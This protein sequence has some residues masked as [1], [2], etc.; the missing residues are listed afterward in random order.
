MMPSGAVETTAQRGD[1]FG[2]AGP[3]WSVHAGGVQGGGG[4]RGQDFGCGA[5]FALP[6][7]SATTS[8]T[9]PS[10]R[11]GRGGGAGSPRVAPLRKVVALRPCLDRAGELV[12][13]VSEAEANTGSGVDNE[14]LRI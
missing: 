3:M 7:R 11:G 1:E 4:K 13:R 14:T 10:G 8:R 9:G 12:I 2:R 6:A 5:T